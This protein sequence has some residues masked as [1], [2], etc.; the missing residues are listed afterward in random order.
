MNIPLEKKQL[1]VILAV[2]M[3]ILAPVLSIT[4][5]FT[6]AYDNQDILSTD[7]GNT[8]IIDAWKYDFTLSK[9][10]KITLEFSVFHENVT[11]NL[12]II[13]LGQYNTLFAT[14]ASP[15]TATGKNFL[16]SSPNINVDPAGISGAGVTIAT[17]TYD[18]FFSIEFMGDGTTIGTDSIWS[19]PGDYVIVVYGTN[20]GA[21]FNFHNIYFNL[22]VKV[23]G[24]GDIS[25]LICNILGWILIIGT[26]VLFYFEKKGG[27]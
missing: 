22:K 4:L 18:D 6:T 20:D 2:I 21:A 5:K 10:Q 19:E 9:D 24:M 25:S 17:C 12:I 7:S 27:N 15:V 8:G 14:N 1:M 13:G 3:F 23:Q 11:A 16:L 26:C